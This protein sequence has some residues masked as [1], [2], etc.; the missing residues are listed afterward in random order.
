MTTVPS[1]PAIPFPTE[2]FGGSLGRLLD[3]SEPS[4][5]TIPLPGKDAPNIVL[6]LLDDVGF[7]TCGTFAAGLQQAFRGDTQS[8]LPLYM[9]GVF[10]SSTLSQ[11]GMVIRWRRERGAGWQGHAFVNG[12][13]ALVTGIVLLVVAATKAHE[14][15]WI[16]ILLIPV[17]VWFFRASKSHAQNPFADSSAFRRTAVFV[18]RQNAR[19]H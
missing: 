14:G 3:E 19:R 12:L 17:H 10:V 8:L 7:G 13:G 4:R 15:A 11:A 2:P 1:G 5:P 18:S 6:I 16:I 9:I